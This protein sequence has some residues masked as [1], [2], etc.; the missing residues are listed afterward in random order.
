MNNKDQEKT[1]NFIT[2]E[3][4]KEALKIVNAYSIQIKNHYENV[5]SEIKQISPFANNTKETL[6][7]D[8]NMSA[9][10]RN[11]FRYGY[12]SFGIK[13]I[14]EAKLSD[15]NGMSITKFSRYRNVGK[16]TIKELKELCYYAGI[17]LS[18]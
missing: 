3:Q 1:S 9:R 17:E 2:I 10:L 11:V 15:L 7:Y 8:A 18:T 12:E 4:Y 6:L 5:E 16:S 14:S 13:R